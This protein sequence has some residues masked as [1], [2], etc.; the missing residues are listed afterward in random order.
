M[1]LVGDL[2]FGVVDAFAAELPDQFLNVGVA[3]QSMVGTAAGLAM[4]G[5]RVFVYS[6]GNFPTLRCLEQIRN[7]VCLHHLDVTVVSVGAG[8]AYGSLGYS[9]HAVEDMAVMRSLP[10]MRVLSPADPVEARAAADL[11][12]ASGGPLYV[13]LGK[14]GEPTLH[15]GVVDVTAPI[16]MRTGSDLTLLATGSIL[17]RALSVADALDARGVSVRVLSCPTVK[18]ISEEALATAALGTRG[19]VTL[20]EHSRAGGFG[21]A[22]LESLNADG[23]R[24]PVLV[25]GMPERP[26]HISG[27]QEYLRDLVGLSVEDLATRIEKF[28]RSLSA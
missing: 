13:R 11:A 14:N 1:L 10:G 7:D 9:H 3:E 20:E 24:T 15:Q 8:V 17:G 26:L 25:L 6:I 21:S 27:S 2:G 12:C 28:A 19:V 18:P 23:G 4:T 5:R 22:V 16:L